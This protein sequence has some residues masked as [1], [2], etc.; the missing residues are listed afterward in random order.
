MTFYSTDA[1]A[2][3][4]RVWQ[5]IE[6]GFN[7]VD[8]TIKEMVEIFETRVENL[9]PKKKSCEENQQEKPPEAH[10]RRLRL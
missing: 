2:V 1:T 7:Y 6:Q 4:T 10:T 8:S 9:K 3:Y 5:M